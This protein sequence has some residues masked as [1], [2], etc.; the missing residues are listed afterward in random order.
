MKDRFALLVAVELRLGIRMYFGRM[1]G[2]NDG[3]DIADIIFHLSV[4]YVSGGKEEKCQQS[5][6]STFFR[7]NEGVAQLSLN[8]KLEI[9]KN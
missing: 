9:V 4:P 6:P 7:I 5:L 8:S 1:N 2:V 3:L